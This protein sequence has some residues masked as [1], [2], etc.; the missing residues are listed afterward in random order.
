MVCIN[1][2]ILTLSFFFLSAAFV[3]VSKP[4]AADKAVE[5]EETES[6]ETKIEAAQSS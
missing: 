3:E 5:A 6:A 4:Q 2:D 1:S